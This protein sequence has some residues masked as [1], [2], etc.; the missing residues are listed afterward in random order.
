MMQGLSDMSSATLSEARDLVL[1]HFLQMHPMKA[2]HLNAIF[3]AVIEMDMD[4]VAG[5]DNDSRSRYMEKLLKQMESLNILTKDEYMFRSSMD[6]HSL[7][8]FELSD[9]LK[10]NN[11]NPRFAVKSYVKSKEHSLVGH[12]S[13]LIQEI[14]KR[15]DS[16]SC[17]SSVESGL[18]TLLKA[19]AKDSL[20]FESNSHQG[21]PSNCK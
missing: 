9:S 18:S 2:A 14:I 20:G 21:Q 16:I 1:E 3:A 12:S 13:F 15:Q 11:H 7:T 19:V 6:S 17:I 8:D 5:M 10:H 4:D